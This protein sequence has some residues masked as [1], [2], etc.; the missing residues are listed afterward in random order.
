M[1]TILLLLTVVFVASTASHDS[2]VFA[3]E[4]DLENSVILHRI[5]REVFKNKVCPSDKV[6]DNI[7]KKCVKP[8]DN[9]IDYK[10]YPEMEYDMDNT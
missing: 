5:R 3:S 10:D 4:S 7:T 2:A 9:S 8:I 6:L 1:Y